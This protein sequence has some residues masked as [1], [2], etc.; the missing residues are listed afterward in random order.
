MKK[1]LALAALSFVLGF[2]ASP[3]EQTAEAYPGMMCFNSGGCGHC[4]VCVKKNEIDPAGT[5]MKISGCS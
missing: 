1:L 4:E 3:S 5:C 2:F